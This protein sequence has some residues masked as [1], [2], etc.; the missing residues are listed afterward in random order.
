MRLPCTSTSPL[1]GA[2]PAAVED[3]HVGEQDVGHGVISSSRCAGEKL[4]Q[5]ALAFLGPFDRRPVAAARQHHHPLA[6]RHGA[7][8][9]PWRARLAAAP[10][11]PRRR[12]P[13]APAPRFARPRPPGRRPALRSC[14][15]R[16]RRPGA[17][18]SRARRPTA[19]GKPLAGVGGDGGPAA[20]PRVI[21]CM[22]A[23]PSRALA[24]RAVIAVARSVR[25][26]DQRAEERHARAPASDA[27]PRC[28]G[29]RWCPSNGPPSGRAPRPGA[30][31]CRAAACDIAL[32]R[33]RAL[34]AAANG[35]CPAGPAR[36]TR[37]RASAGISG[38]KVLE[39]PPRPCTQ[40]TAGPSPSSSTAT[41]SISWNGIGQVRPTRTGSR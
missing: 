12:S 31:R 39:L 32:D 37:C 35:R 10:R 4:A 30:R 40:T 36:S 18:G 21:S 13:A 19:T 23:A 8:G 7:A 1:K 6:G 38:V 27:R 3:A 17:S 16:P 26:R 5:L 22:P 20:A 15:H 11:R 25:R 24:A 28:A 2:S 33:Q 9:R 29:R 14:A 41:R 34:G